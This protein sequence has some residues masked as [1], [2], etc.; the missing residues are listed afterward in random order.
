MHTVLISIFRGTNGFKIELSRDQS[1]WTLVLTGNLA[2]AHGLSC[3]NIPMK[4][5]SLTSGVDGQFLKFTVTSYYGVGG[6]LYYFE[7][8]FD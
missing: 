7:V 1:N 8:L 3:S 4:E 2:T 5:Y 6:G